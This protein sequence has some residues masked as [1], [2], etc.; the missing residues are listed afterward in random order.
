MTYTHGH[1][2]SVLRSHRVRTAENSCG[3][4]LEHLAGA[5]TPLDELSLLA[6]GCGP[7]TITADLARRVSSVVGI[8]P[9][10]PPQPSAPRRR[11]SPAGVGAPG[12]PDRRRL[13][14]VH[15]DLRHPR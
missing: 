14:D 9:G 15:L 5:E 13:L 8:D 2:E 7:A 12:G 3:Y 6:V 4:L 11:P 10:H 1:H